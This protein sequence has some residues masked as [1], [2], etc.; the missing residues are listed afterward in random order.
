VVDVWHC[1]GLSRRDQLLHGAIVGFLQALLGLFLAV[2]R[3]VGYDALQQFV[4]RV[5]DAL[6]VE[7]GHGDAL[8]CAAGMLVL[9]NIW[10]L[11]GVSGLGLPHHSLGPTMRHRATNIRSCCAHLSPSTFAQYTLGF[12][13]EQPPLT[14]SY[15]ERFQRNGELPPSGQT[16][17]I[18]T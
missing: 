17:A 6:M 15:R 10:P 9:N 2:V 12:V 4:Q 3:V 13:M 14:C 1:F 11:R 8:F 7:R 16:G 5:P 18:E